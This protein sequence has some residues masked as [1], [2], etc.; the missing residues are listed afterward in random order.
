[1]N[2]RTIKWVLKKHIESGEKTLWTWENNNFTC[3]YQNYSESSRIYTAVQLLKI[4]NSYK[5]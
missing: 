4:L 5:Q 1:M 3:I 2:Y